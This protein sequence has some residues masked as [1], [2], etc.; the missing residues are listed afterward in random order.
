LTFAEEKVD[1]DRINKMMDKLEANFNKKAL[2]ILSKSKNDYI[3]RLNELIAK[4]DRAGIKKLDLKFQNDYKKIIKDILKASFV[5]GKNNV[6]KEMNVQ[7][8]ADPND[9]LGNYDVLADTIAEKQMLDIK[10]KAKQGLVEGLGK[11]VPVAQVIGDIDKAI[12][13][14]IKKTAVDTG[15]IIVG[16][17]IN[18]GRDTV[19]TKYRSK[20]YALQRSE[21]LDSKT[22]NYCLS[23]DGR[24]V[25]L[26]DKMAKVGL[27]HSRCRGLWVEIL[28]D[29]KDKPKISGIP[30][31]LRDRFGGAINILVQPKKP[32]VKKDSLANK[33]LT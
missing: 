11:G 1:F 3:K 13:E 31:A 9:L 8:P 29:E 23:I 18:Q 33:F 30:K 6:A 28:V 25:S 19:F 26:N 32:I 14:Q 27:F 5:F 17:A 22:C 21:L 4:K 2:A 10:Y 20:I 15:S 12:E 24:I 7:A 16:E